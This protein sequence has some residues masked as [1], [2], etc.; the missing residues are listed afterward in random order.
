VKYELVLAPGI[1][2]AA[3]RIAAAIAALFVASPSV[4]KTTTLGGRTPVPNAFSVR[5]FASYA[6]FPGIEKLWYQR[7]ETCAAAKAP[8]SVRTIQA[9]MTFHRWR[10][11]R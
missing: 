5:W 8:K 6:D 11:T 4:W 10:A 2:A 7:F 9:V 1:V 3:R